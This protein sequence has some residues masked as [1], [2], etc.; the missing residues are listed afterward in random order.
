MEDKSKTIYDF[1]FHMLNYKRQL[2][3]FLFRLKDKKQC[4]YYSEKTIYY[5]NNATTFNILTK[6][7]V[8][9]NI[10]YKNAM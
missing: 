8:L 1:H 7:Y 9:K 10:S 5:S 2:L 3:T 4:T 6:L